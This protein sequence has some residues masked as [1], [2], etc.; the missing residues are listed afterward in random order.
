VAPTVLR[1]LGLKESLLDA[2]RLEGTQRL[3]N[4]DEC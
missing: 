2:V 4:G 1:A 3:T